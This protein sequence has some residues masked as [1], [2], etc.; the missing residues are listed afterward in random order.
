[1]L[2][3]RLYHALHE[4]YGCTYG[5]NICIE[6]FFHQYWILLAFILK[7]VLCFKK[8]CVQ[9]VSLRES[10]PKPR[11]E[12][13]EYLDFTLAENPKGELRET[14]TNRDHS[15]YLKFRLSN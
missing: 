1:M 7:N 9:E 11:G 4:S 13:E 12:E 5:F 2:L 10:N 15:A 6:C 8:I 3:L 14:K